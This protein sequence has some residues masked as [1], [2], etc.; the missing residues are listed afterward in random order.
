MM[1]SGIVDHG[2]AVT[3]TVSMHTCKK[4]GDIVAD[5]F[6]EICQVFVCNQCYCFKVHKTISH[7]ESLKILHSVVKYCKDHEKQS[8][9]QHLDLT[10]Q[11]EDVNRLATNHVENINLYLKKGKESLHICARGEIVKIKADKQEK[12]D[13]LE[14]QISHLQE[15]KSHCNEVKT[16]AEL[17]IKNAGS[18][19]FPKEAQTFLSGYFLNSFPEEKVFPN[20][21]SFILPLYL[22]IK[23][24]PQRD[25]FFKEQLLGYYVPVGDEAPHYLER[26]DTLRSGIRSLYSGRTASHSIDFRSG[27][28]QGSERS[29]RSQSTLHTDK[30]RSDITRDTSTI[31]EITGIRAALQTY[32]D[33][34]KIK[35]LR[36]KTVTN[37]IFKE[38]SI[39]LAA[40][41]RSLV[42]KCT[43]FLH[44]K[45]ADYKVVQKKKKNIQNSDNSSF[46]FL[47]NGDII[48]ALKRSN[49]IYRF[50]TKS[51]KF[52]EW[53]SRS[54]LS[55]AAMCG[56]EDH[57]YIIHDDHHEHIAVLDSDIRI[58][59]GLHQDSDGEIDM[60]VT[61]WNETTLNTIALCTT[62]P[63]SVRLV[64]HE[65]GVVWKLKD[66][67]LVRPCSVT[68]SA[69]G[70][71]Y[72]ADSKTDRVNHE[73]FYFVNYFATNDQLSSIGSSSVRGSS[74]FLPH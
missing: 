9:Q 21:L 4:H 71:I 35:G 18:S 69:A 50:C 16:N 38:K 8:K 45:D 43:Q 67:M 44:V 15:V 30:F 62:C 47:S 32:K 25:N 68:S 65:S 54:D 27:T 23:D 57:V 13:Q 17:L 64:S 56:N 66:P 52:K 7:T 11:I 53:L 29:L 22:Q 60:C 39:W 63:A 3:G 20:S 59:T 42:G 5:L 49:T 10:K 36:L 14:M 31:R 41:Y 37:V 40:C 70:I 51:N 48:F 72:F 24:K 26:Q 1:P 2:T 74:F 6:C 19:S 61:T 55:V 28:P 34:G 12:Q 33:I 58:K 46:M 73:L